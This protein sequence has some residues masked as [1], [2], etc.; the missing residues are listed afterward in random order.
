MLFEICVNKPKEFVIETFKNISA[1]LVHC[2]YIKYSFAGF[3]QQNFEIN[4]NNSEDIL[5]VCW[6]D[7]N[8]KFVSK[9]SSWKVIQPFS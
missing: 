2:W 8:S 7:L 3:C 5:L 9:L 6:F 4:R 1:E